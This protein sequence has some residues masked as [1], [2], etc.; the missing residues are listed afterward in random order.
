MSLLT[1]DP[2]P[3]DWSPR[4]PRFSARSSTFDWHDPQLA[5]VA[6]VWFI[7]PS[8]STISRLLSALRDGSLAVFSDGSAHAGVAGTCAWGIATHAEEIAILAAGFRIPGPPN[9]QCSYR[10]E[11]AGLLGIVTF[12]RRILFTFPETSGTLTFATDS[13]SVLGRVFRKGHPAT[14]ADHSWDL[15][16]LCQSLL[17]GLVGIKWQW[18]HVKGHQDA[19]DGPLDIWAR[20]NVFVDSCATA[21]YERLRPECT[22]QFFSF[23]LPPISCGDSMVVS[24]LASTI[25]THVLSPPA[26]DHWQRLNRFGSGTCTMV[27]WEA[28]SG[29]LALLPQGHRHWVIK[30]TAHRSAVG[31]EM[32]RRRQWQNPTCPRC[33]HEMETADHVVTCAHPDVKARW[34]HFL[35]K[36]DRWLALRHTHPSMAR[37][38]LSHLRSWVDGSPPPQEFTSTPGL[39]EALEDQLQ[40]GWT[41]A[42]WGHWSWRWADVQQAYYQFLG[43]R[44]S[45]RRWLSL[46]IQQVWNTA[47][48][49]WEHRNAILHAAEVER[50][51]AERCAAIRDAYLSPLRN[52]PA[53]RLLF[54][55]PLDTRLQDPPH[56]QIAFLR[57]ISTPVASAASRS[58]RRQQRCL[59]SFF[60]RSVPTAR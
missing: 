5:E 20:R 31:V 42:I 2:T 30:A 29:A 28:R 55:C 59:R 8:E 57:R 22:P 60:F 27:Q 41:N 39:R 19:G 3:V 45:G 36:L 34:M 12:L 35:S 48:D 32:V 11:L 4:F 44:Q 14:V 18:R 47:W 6:P 13:D 7:P 51:R 21:V 10:S 38:I 15:L 23:P 53:W 58:L 49:Q 37:M 54:R 26:M 1:W 16:S 17:N 56:L 24:E 50:K 9:S 52:S 25:R 43:K 33:G 46:L 40:L